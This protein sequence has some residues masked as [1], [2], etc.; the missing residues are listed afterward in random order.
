MRLDGVDVSMQ[1][2]HAKSSTLLDHMDGTFCNPPP[3]PPLAVQTE[4]SN[5]ILGSQRSMLP[6]L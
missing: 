4:I 5:A 6:P 2:L 3:Q 1:V